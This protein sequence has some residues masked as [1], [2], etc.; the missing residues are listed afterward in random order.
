M[1]VTAFS[2]GRRY[3]CVKKDLGRRDRVFDFVVIGSDPKGRSRYKLCRLEVIEH[4]PWERNIGEDGKCGWYCCH[5]V[6]QTYS[7]KHLK[8][9]GVLVEE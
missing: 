3:R 9:Y 8:E 1:R 5:G 6:E 2:V 7:H 4:G